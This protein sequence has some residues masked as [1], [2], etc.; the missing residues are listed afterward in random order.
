MAV[1]SWNQDRKPTV[2][3]YPP[4]RPLSAGGIGIPTIQESGGEGWLSASPLDGRGGSTADIELTAEGARPCCRRP[5]RHR[6]GSPLGH[7]RR[8]SGSSISVG[9]HRFPRR[10]AAGG[11]EDVCAVGNGVRSTPVRTP[12]IK[13]ASG[14]AA[15]IL[16]TQ[17]ASASFTL[18]IAACIG[19]IMPGMRLA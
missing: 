5:A 14:C 10:G 19:R 18:N 13:V 3:S 2:P 9:R 1:D 8:G 7:S 16:S 11:R 6:P 12:W 15:D 4:L 17:A